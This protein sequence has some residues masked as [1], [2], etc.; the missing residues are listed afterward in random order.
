ME[1]DYLFQVQTIED[2]SHI[3]FRIP[4]PKGSG[5]YVEKELKKDYKGIWSSAWGSFYV[6]VPK[7]KCVKLEDI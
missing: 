5:I 1:K 2:I 7:D 6:K 4:I 3:G